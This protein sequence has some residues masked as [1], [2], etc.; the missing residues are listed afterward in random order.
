MNIIVVGG[1]LSGLVAAMRLQE[2]G[3]EVSLLESRQRVGGQLIS[4]WD[5]GFC[6]DHS[7][8]AV[9]TG[10]R[11]ILG[12]VTQLGLSDTLL[13]LRPLQVTQMHRG[14][15]VS[16]ESQRLLGVAAIPGLRKWDAG[17]LLRWSRLMTRYRPLLDPTQ[18]ELAE[19]LDSRSVAD[20]IRLYFG[21]TTLSHWVAPEVQASYSGHVESLS[22][23]TAMLAWIS[24]GV[25]RPH[26][27][28]HGL[29]RTGVEPALKLAAESLMIRHGVEATRIDEMAGG[30]FSVECTGRQGGHGLLEADAVVLATS[31]A[32]AARIAGSQLSSAEQDFLTGVKQRPAITMAIALNHSPSQLARLVRIPAGL[33]NCIEGILV[34]PGMEGGRAPLGCGIVTVQATEAFANENLGRG[35]ASVEK[36]LL[37]EFS[38]LLPGLTGSLRQVRVERRR[39]AVPAFDVGA[40]RALARFRRVLAD[41]RDLGRRLYFAGDYLVSADA[42]GRTMAG[43][44]AASD[45]IEDTAT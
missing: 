41:Q 24:R 28:V 3:H 5:Q 25:G 14:R 15:P 9:H 35:E 4:D 43:F 18:P 40:Y 42:E 6:F 29:F 12:W 8:Q 23:V 33:S 26:P 13:P 30:G 16:I 22:R 2:A 39:A 36:T 31:A 7:L 45:L 11:Y 32:E 27:C 34:E 20:F 19:S 38:R 10:N 1:G 21:A 44:R 37:E 17:R